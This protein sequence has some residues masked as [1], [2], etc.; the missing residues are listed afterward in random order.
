MMIYFFCMVW[1]FPACN[2]SLQKVART[3]QKEKAIVISFTLFS[4]FVLGVTQ[5]KK[6]Q[7]WKIVLSL[8]LTVTFA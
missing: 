5:Q 7:T 3:H 6:Q 4:H 2:I 1:V 8:Y